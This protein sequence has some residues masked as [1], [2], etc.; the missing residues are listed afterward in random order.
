MKIECN[1]YYRYYFITN[2]GISPIR[3]VSLLLLGMHYSSYTCIYIDSTM[4][5]YCTLIEISSQHSS[6]NGIGSSGPGVIVILLLV[7][8]KL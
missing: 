8:C 6:K 2:T 4:I 5:L 7:S 3:V 1:Q